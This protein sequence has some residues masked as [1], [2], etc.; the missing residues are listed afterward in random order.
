MLS[1]QA[2]WNVTEIDE[3]EVVL[4]SDKTGISKIAARFLVQR[5]IKTKEEIDAFLHM[6]EE[7][8]HDPFQ[9]KDMDKAVGRIKT[10]IQAGERI[11]IFGDYDADGV[12]STSLMYMTLREIGAEAGFYVPNRFTEGYGPNEN[13]FR[14]AAEEGVSLI[15]TVDTGISAVHEAQVAKELGIDLIITDHHEPPP[16]LP[17]GFAVIN[18]KQEGCSYPNSHLAGVGVAFKVAQAL[19]G[20][21]PEEYYDL[22]AIGTVA[23]LVSLQGENRFL[24][25]KG[26]QALSRYQR[27]GL[28]ALLERTGS[29]PQELNEEQIGFLIGPRLNAAGRLDAADPAVELL[30]TGDLAE[31]DELAQMVDDL[32]KERQ[33]IVKEIAAEAETKVEEEGVPPVIVVGNEGWNAGVIGIVASRLV[34]KYYRPVIVLSYDQE[35]GLAKGSARSIKG[36]DMFRSLSQCRE[37]LPHFGGHPMAAGMTLKIEHV[38]LLKNK[39]TDIALNSLSEDDWKKSLDIDLPVSLEEV[40]L[41]AI[42]DLQQMAPFG[43]GNPAPKFLIDDV[44]LQMIKKIG[45]NGDHLKLVVENTGK[46]KQLDC[47][48]FRMGNLHDHI[49]PLSRVSAVGKLAVNEWNGQSK[50]QFIIEDLKVK[51][52]QLFDFRGDKRLWQN[53]PFMNLG[54]CT[55]VVFQESSSQWFSRLPGHW[56]IVRYFDESADLEKIEKADNILLLDLPD[57][58]EAIKQVISMAHKLERLF[59]AFIHE[60]DYFFEAV[61]TRDQFKWFYGFLLKRQS[62]DIKNRTHELAKYKGW[63]EN[64]VH[65]M[66]KVF[67]ELDFVKMNNG[68]IEI[69]PQPQKKD[70]TASSTYQKHLELSHIENELYYSSYRSLKL[71]MDRVINNDHLPSA[72]QA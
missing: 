24:T 7:A 60:K 11:L 57:T 35:T 53:E 10:A 22:A 18:P 45:A 34:E 43:M 14:Q 2:V 62:F 3:E 23:D 42:Y 8:V 20:R 67:F 27:P 71:W 61:P 49:S 4:L 63:S 25:I 50:P 68:V 41:Q 72:I 29:N 54:L 1:S 51:E 12:T 26:V 13:A 40:S 48:G 32:N 6:D 58:T 9:L 56:E 19:L 5:G 59:A 44:N 15:I 31:A 46:D 70:L 69:N 39:L 38:E 33:T 36:F 28:K 37:W 21:I 55:V 30:I 17:E 65:F 16:E 64:A 47:I 52:W 66:S